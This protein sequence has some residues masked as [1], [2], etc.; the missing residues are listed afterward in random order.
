VS[1]RPGAPRL[2][3]AGAAIAVAVAVVGFLTGT[4]APA[5]P[6]GYPYPGGDGPGAVEPVPAYGAVGDDRRG[7]N[8]GMYDGAF[9]RLRQGLP[10]VL[11]LVARSGD[12]EAARAARS[13]R[14]AYDGAPPTIPHAIDQRGY[15]SCLACHQDGAVIGDRIAPVMSHERYASCTQ[16]HVPMDSTVDLGRPPPVNAFSG[17]ASPGPGTRAWPGAPPTIPHTTAMRERCDSCHGVAGSSPLRS[18]HPF[19]Q[20]CQQC[21]VRDAAH[22]ARHPFPT[23][24]AI[25]E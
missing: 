19:R 18:T 6:D 5:A 4:R 22:D 7:P 20:S 15:P 12:L 21:H 17:L 24:E 23:P 13:G 25:H 9:T 8:A 3:Y 2:L 11:D 1:E 14:R 16:C 10:S